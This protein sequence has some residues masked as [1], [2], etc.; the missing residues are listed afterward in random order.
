MPDRNKLNFAFISLQRLQDNKI[1]DMAKLVKDRDTRT[2]KDLSFML[3]FQKLPPFTSG[4]RALR[5][6]KHRFYT[7]Q[8][9]LRKIKL[10]TLTLLNTLCNQRIV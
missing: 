3:C 10:T 4:L 9:I 6:P 1:I 8:L 5:Y 2:K 7:I